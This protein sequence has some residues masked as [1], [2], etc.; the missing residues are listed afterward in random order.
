MGVVVYVGE[1]PEKGHETVLGD[2]APLNTMATTAIETYARGA[3][4][5]EQSP[6]SVEG[7]SVIDNLENSL[8]GP[9]GTFERSDFILESVVTAEEEL[10]IKA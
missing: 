10:E 8:T 7:S 2:V 4:A 9:K 1:G 5:G 6:K 3:K